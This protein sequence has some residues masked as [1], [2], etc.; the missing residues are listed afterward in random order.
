MLIR[1]TERI[2]SSS[3]HTVTPLNHYNHTPIVC[4]CVWV[5]SNCAR[6][7]RFVEGHVDHDSRCN[8]T[9]AGTSRLPSQVNSCNQRKEKSGIRLMLTPVSRVRAH[10]ASQGDHSWPKAI[11]VTPGDVMGA[12]GSK[13]K[14]GRPFR[15]VLV[16]KARSA[17]ASADRHSSH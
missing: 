9:A 11:R 14:T 2:D 7:L 13:E 8:S 15:G 5:P 12:S 17:K 3:N 6:S 1:V 4:V 10:C 16:H